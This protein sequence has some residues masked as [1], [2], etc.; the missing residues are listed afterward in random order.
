VIAEKQFAADLALAHQLADIASAVSLSHFR[1]TFDRWSKADGSIATT[2]DLA[3]EDALRA[4]LGVERP[5]D[6]ILGE[7]RG[8]S[9]SN[10]RRWIL[11]AIDGTVEFAAGSPEW[12]TLIALEVDG[13][14]VVGVCDEP[15][16]TRRY[17]AVRGGGAFRSNA[18]GTPPTKLGVSATHELAAARSYVPPPQWQPDDR[19]R[20]IA[21]ALAEA[22]NPQPQTDHPAL[23]VAFGGYDVAVFLTAGAWDLAAPALVVEEAGGRF[24]DLSGRSDITSGTAIFSNGH[25]HDGVLRLVSQR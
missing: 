17:W 2:A 7:E 3:V 1:Q 25:V 13:R 4:R 10:A 14:I 8:E 21:V 15:A 19:S 12:A 24:T 22:T 23:Q 5:A 18:P 9:G 16:N 6:A 11:D 20:R